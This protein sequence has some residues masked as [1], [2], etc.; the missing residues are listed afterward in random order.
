M[1]ETRPLVKSPSESLDEYPY[2]Q[3]NT[4]TSGDAVA[5][6]K[7]F[8][9]DPSLSLQTYPYENSPIDINGSDTKNIGNNSGKANKRDLVGFFLCGL[10]NNFG[11]VLFLTAASDL[12]KDQNGLV[13][14]CE[15]VPSLLLQLIAPFFMHLIPYSLRIITVFVLG[16]SSLMIVAWAD[17]LHGVPAQGI[18][19]I[20]LMGVVFSSVGCGGGE[21]TFLAMSS[22]YHKDAVSA[23]S[24]GT[25]G[26]GIFGGVCYAVLST[27]GWSTRTKLMLCTPLFIV[28][29]LSAFLVLTGKHNQNGFCSRG[30]GVIKQEGSITPTSPAST[31][32]K[33]MY[34]PQL[35]K[36]MVPLFVV[37]Y[38]EYVILSGVLPTVVFRRGF[39]DAK[40]NYYVY[41]LAY[42]VGV[43]VS[44][45]SVN[46]YPIKRLWLPAVIQCG[47]CAFVLL[48]AF[49]RFIPAIAF[50]VP[51][52]FVVGLLGG[53][54][55]VNA[56]Y[57]MSQQMPSQYK[58]FGMG[59]VSVANS[60]GISLSSVTSIFLQPWLLSH[61]H[62]KFI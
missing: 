45:S 21:I 53:G 56:F 14:F 8:V 15:I 41:T 48:D 23:W 4:P 52:I 24:S 49:F 31:K 57:L 12:A 61:Q 50:V 38:A 36:Y 44:R 3:S 10:L 29:L 1:K 42:Q 18:L 7:H 2:Y 9:V 55:Y 54:T 34:I 5:K 6:E 62:K 16:V 26:A 35:F 39:V 27:F 32:L 30:G 28:M 59:L 19:A 20:K 51:V 25:G 13:L 37:Y 47:L 33:I 43:F 22:Y 46:I 60:I 17:A 11:Y 58:E 40:S